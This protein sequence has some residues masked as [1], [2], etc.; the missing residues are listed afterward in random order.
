[1]VSESIRNLLNQQ[2]TKELHASNLYLAMAGHFASANLEGMANWMRVQSEEE[3]GHALRIFDFV[4]ERGGATEV[5]AVEQPPVEFGAPIDVFRQA[6]AHEQKVTASINNIYA[7]AVA[8]NDYAT[9]VFLQWFIGEQVEEE[10][11]ATAM[12]ER[13]AMAG[14]DRAALLMLDAEMKARAAD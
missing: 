9:Q 3:R 10:A 8:E 12:V 7:A 5:G 11:S 14:D 13:L 2:V 1:M 6:L 4:I